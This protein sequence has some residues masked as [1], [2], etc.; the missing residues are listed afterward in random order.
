[1]GSEI[2]IEPLTFAGIACLAFV[3]LRDFLA[4]FR[5]LWSLVLVIS[6]AVSIYY[7]Q[8]ATTTK[9]MLLMFFMH[10]P[11]AIAL[12]ASALAGSRYLLRKA[13]AIRASR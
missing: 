8:F 11:F 2:H 1:M 13:C 4:R 7:S 10:L 12:S 9:N 6:V 3:L 5:T